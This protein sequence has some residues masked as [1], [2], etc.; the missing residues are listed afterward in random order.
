M[1]YENDT[2]TKHLPTLMKEQY[3]TKSAQAG[4]RLAQVENE[5]IASVLEHL[6]VDYSTWVEYAVLLL[7]KDLTDPQRDVEALRRSYLQFWQNKP[8]TTMTRNAR[9]SPRLR[10]ETEEAMHLLWGATKFATAVRWALLRAAPHVLAQPSR[11]QRAQASLEAER[12]QA[13]ARAAR[14][15]ENQRIRNQQVLVP[16][17]SGFIDP[18]TL[19]G[20]S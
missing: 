5:L 16:H 3:G 7:L 17:G 19:R 9:I 14:A 4:V 20:E 1:T 15:A 6:G 2:Y 10:T 8:K 13:A 12:Q 18:K 11:A